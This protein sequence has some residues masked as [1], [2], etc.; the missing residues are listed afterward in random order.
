MDDVWAISSS[1]ASGMVVLILRAGPRP[2]VAAVS[3]AELVSVRTL[4]P[5]VAEAVQCGEFSRVRLGSAFRNSIGRDPFRQVTV[6]PPQRGLFA[7]WLD[8]A[9][10][11]V[12]LSFAAGNGNTWLRFAGYAFA[13][14]ALG[15]LVGY[16]WRWLR[17]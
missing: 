15:D 5:E 11:V 7:W 3:E 4:L 17:R 2:L 10:A 12:G 6:A 14:V 16:G 9:Y 13:V 8:C 1:G